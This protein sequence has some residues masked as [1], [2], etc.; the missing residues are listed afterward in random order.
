MVNL[1]AP[2][3][4]VPAPA[5]APAELPSALPGRAD[6]G[7]TTTR[8][9][10]GLTVTH[11]VG[12]SV[13][14]GWHGTEL[15]DYVYTPEEPRAES[16]R[17]YLHPM[18]TL[19]GNVVSLYRPHN[20]LWH[21]GLCFGV[22]NFGPYNFWGGS[23]YV[24]GQGY[25]SL[26]NLGLVAHVDFPALRR[27]ADAV[28]LVE[29]LRW[30]GP[31]GSPVVSERRRLAVA[32]WANLST[33]RLQFETV[34]RNDTDEVITVGSPTTQGRENAGYG[35]LFWHGP[36]SFIGG[37]VLTEDGPG[38]DELMGWRGPWMGFVG[39]HDGLGPPAALTSTL[40]FR[41]DPANVGG[42][43]RWFV[44]TEPYACLG[45]AP[46]FD[47]E[48]AFAPRTELRLRYDVLVA[49]GERDVAGCARLAERA[50]M[51]DLLTDEPRRHHADG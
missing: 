25:R 17:P 19:A 39:R 26:D 45:P 50:G 30:V 31:D 14:V 8:P 44:R 5:T 41:D 49:D 7:A 35:G 27:D 9:S 43:T 4:A 42:R 37:Q 18:R 34:L 15:F 46:F 32:V 3:V 24:R 51:T 38:A 11:D 20:H 16:P 10:S 21:K 40:V 22:S 36:R 28:R 12:R 23:T 13:R 6:S 29:R 1:S 33:W 2:A 48:Y 47:R